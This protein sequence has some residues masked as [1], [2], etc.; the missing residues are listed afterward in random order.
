M[1]IALITPSSGQSRA[2]AV[3][4][5]TVASLAKLLT[6][7]GYETTV[8]TL[9]AVEAGGARVREGAL[10]LDAQL[11]LTQ[12][13]DR[14]ADF[15]LIH[16][17]AGA[18][19]LGFAPLISPPLI[20]TVT[21]ELGQFAPDLLRHHRERVSFVAPSQLDCI[22]EIAC[23]AVVPW[24]VATARTRFQPEASQ[25][26]VFG[27]ELSPDDSLQDAIDFVTQTKRNL[28][29]IGRPSDR[30]WF[31]SITS[32]L[33]REHRLM[34]I[35]DAGSDQADDA[36][37]GAPALLLGDCSAGLAVLV[38]LDAM[39]H[40][41][42][43]VSL[44]LEPLSGVLADRSAVACHK[45]ALSAP[46][47]LAI[48]K[49]LDRAACRAW[50]EQNASAEAM[51]D[52]HAKLY[53]QVAA[54]ARR[55]DRRPWGYYVVLADEPDHKVKRIVVF[56]GKRLSLQRHRRRAEHW[57]VVGG[58]A[59]VTRNDEELHLTSGQSVDIPSGA[60]HRVKNPGSADMAF[61]E[62]QTGDYFGE[63]DIERKEDDFGRS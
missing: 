28:V 21:R 13:L 55:I 27:G 56:P 63:D 48:V 14:N 44:G 18:A 57:Y 15:D 59:L 45:V 38:A 20:A 1:R 31:D 32:P 61:I 11:R 34:W 17:F 7:R 46:A 4:G 41:T 39:A 6:Q 50:V 37:A 19:A 47:T 3:L 24:G 40:G 12:L 33:M 53:E 9:D 54:G 60:W 8:A 43:V 26:L 25:D 36:V 2:D 22:D 30:T 16:S 49:E 29:V 42:P 58:E 52:A 35:A 10:S 23:K 51:T 5:R 62:V